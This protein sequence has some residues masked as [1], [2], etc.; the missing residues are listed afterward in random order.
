MLELPRRS[1]LQGVIAA[2]SAPAIVRVAS[3]MPV[4]APKLIT[5]LPRYGDLFVLAEDIGAAPPVRPKQWVI[6]NGQTYYFPEAPMEAPTVY[7]DPRH[8]PYSKEAET[9]VVIGSQGT[10]HLKV[11]DGFRVPKSRP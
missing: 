9:R 4:K 10:Q 6:F 5:E 8:G 2:C 7:K 11:V 1:F 3:I